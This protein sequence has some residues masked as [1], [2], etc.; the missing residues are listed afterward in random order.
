MASAAH[1]FYSKAEVEEFDV[2]AGIHDIYLDNAHK[3]RRNV[4]KII[5]HPDFG[6]GGHRNDI[7]LLKV[8]AIEMIRNSC[9]LIMG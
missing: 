5:K 2:S 9:P 7:A 1:C 4:V 6:S 3:Q 8:R